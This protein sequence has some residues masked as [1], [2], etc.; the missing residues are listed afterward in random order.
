MPPPNG[1]SVKFAA[2]GWRCATM[3]DMTTPRIS[4]EPDLLE[5]GDRVR[6]R[7]LPYPG[8]GGARF[9]RPMHVRL[10]HKTC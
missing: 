3:S 9:T 2:E 5:T 6:Q 10:L 7:D 4:N 8:P 1:C